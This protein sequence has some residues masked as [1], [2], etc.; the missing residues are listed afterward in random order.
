MGVAKRG[1]FVHANESTAESSEHR[2]LAVA[3]RPEPRRIDMRMADNMQDLTGLIL[4]NGCA[5]RHYGGCSDDCRTA[6][7]E[8]TPREFNRLPGQGSC[9]PVA[10]RDKRNQ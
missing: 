1:C 5:K 10:R 7:Y 9:L 6:Q 4:R 3:P 2:I 8:I